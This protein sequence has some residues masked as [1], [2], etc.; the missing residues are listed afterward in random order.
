MNDRG[1]FARAPAFT[2]DENLI[3]RICAAYR[4]SCSAFGRSDE[5]GESQW[6]VLNGQKSKAHEALITGEGAAEMLRNP[7]SN[8]LFMGFDSLY[9]SFTEK[10]RTSPTHQAAIASQI[11]NGLERLAQS[12]GA[13]RI[14]NPESPNQVRLYDKNTVALL[15]LIAAETTLDLSFPNP[16][17][18]EFGVSTSRGVISLRA[19]FAVY[20]ANRLRQLLSMTRNK[21]ILEIGAGLGR[22]AF[23]AYS[24]GMRDYAIIDLPLA[25]AAQAYFLGRTIGPE[26]I[27]L[28]GETNEAPVRVL[29][30]SSLDGMD[31]G[32]VINV[33]SLT[34]MDRS[35]AARYAA[36]ARDHS[37]IFLSINH[38]VN[39]FTVREMIRSAM[40]EAVVLR[41]PYLMRPG[42]VEEVVFSGR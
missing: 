35:F 41:Y 15:P 38:E 24:M 9:A 36:F 14:P 10:L 4:H 13:V 6:S 22:T 2:D 20:Q 19:V 16:F 5:V 26:N 7:C 40:P 28:S 1:T 37:E 29:T 31:V 8:N 17:P 27:A 33:D 34:E 21:S 30:P 3:K 42:Y 25:N 11:E 12:I 23:Y 39:L 18:D 32:V